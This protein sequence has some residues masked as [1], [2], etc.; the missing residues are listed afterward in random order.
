MSIF[1]EKWWKNSPLGNYGIIVVFTERLFDLLKWV[2]PVV[3]FLESRT[4]VQK[5]QSGLDSDTVERQT[6]R[7]A[8]NVE[9][10]IAGY[11]LLEVALILLVL[12]TYPYGSPLIPAILGL[13]ATWRILDTLQVTVN[14]SLF[15]HLRVPTEHLE[16]AS[17][18]R[19]VIL[20]LINYLELLVLFGVL[21]SIVPELD[22][23]NCTELDASDF[24]YF[25]VI[26]QT[27][28]GY[29]DIAPLFWAKVVAVI[30]GVIGLF[31]AV[32]ILARIVSLLPKANDTDRKEDGGRLTVR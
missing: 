31:F 1:L 25:S 15:D 29:G 10:F 2:S 14:M 4:Q 30:Q 22:I 11:L 13:I 23:R 12:G 20:T 18:T 16:M 32:V 24:F 8:K 5:K 9:K 26:S 3:W 21:Y 19:T 7:R 28:I 17:I 6:R 27:S